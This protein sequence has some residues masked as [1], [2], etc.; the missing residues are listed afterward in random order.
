MIFNITP[1]SI[2]SNFTG[3]G[4]VSRTEKLKPKKKRAKRKTKAKSKLK[5]NGR[6]KRKR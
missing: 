6:S 2:T 3:A 5:K 4:E 1:W